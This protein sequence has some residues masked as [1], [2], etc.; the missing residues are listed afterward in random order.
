MES[1][2]V[3]VIGAYGVMESGG[4]LNK[5]GTLPIAICAKAMSKE[6]FVMAESIKFL[7]DFPLNQSTISNEYKVWKF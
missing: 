3:V 7:K 6:V 2:D 1:L 4:I 5:I